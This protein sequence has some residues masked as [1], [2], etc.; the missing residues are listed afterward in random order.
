MKMKFFEVVELITAK[1]TETTWV[2]IRLVNEYGVTPAPHAFSLSCMQ[3]IGIH[4][5]L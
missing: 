2:N 3:G 4:Q 5:T 1:G